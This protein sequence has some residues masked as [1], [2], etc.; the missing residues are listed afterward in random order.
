MP[1]TKE[2]VIRMIQQMPNETTVDDI[3]AELSFKLQV[4]QGLKELDAGRGIPQQQVRER[5]GKWTAQ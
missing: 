1:A 4:D 3:F 2:A 5:L